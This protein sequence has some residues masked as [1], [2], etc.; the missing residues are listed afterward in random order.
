MRGAQQR[1]PL[2][3][4]A[5][6]SVR[7]PVRTEAFRLRPEQLHAVSEVSFALWPGETLGLVGESGSGK[8]T[9]GKQ[10]VG[11]ERPNEGRIL[12]RGLDLVRAKKRELRAV[13]TELQMIFQDSGASLNPRK[14]IYEIL[15]A[16][17]LYHGLE[18]KASV[19]KR[20]DR[21]LEMVGL[22]KSSKQRY[23]HE[24]SGGQRQR[25][26]IAR[27]L[28]LNPRLIVCDEPVS[29]LDV[30]IQAQILNL[31]LDLQEE[32]DLTYLFIAHGLAAVNY[33]SDRIAVMYLG[34]IVEL[35]T[36]E[37][38]F[39]RPLHPYTQA[40]IRSAP[41][42]DPT[43]RDTQTPLLQGEPPSNIHLPPGCAFHPRCPHAVASCRSERPQL[44]ALPGTGDGEKGHF[45]ACPVMAARAGEAAPS[46][47]VR[48]G[49]C[50]EAEVKR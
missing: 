34:R 1:G 8:S 13:R 36:A 35:A 5:D 40:L 29:A 38:L 2:I 32:L 50:P 12:Y 22:P 46:G 14:H 15:A 28:S 23:A 3:E 44:L 47:P 33:V 18:S 49:R 43:A 20:I 37:E 45:L 24:F 30:S 7:Y 27:A 6:M 17:L 21:L 25:I 48:L 10:L 4:V 16:P 9:V 39:G 31:L 11:L 19:E 42:P 41:V 26:G